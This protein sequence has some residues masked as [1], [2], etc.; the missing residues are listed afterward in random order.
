MAT[1]D[2]K[3]SSKMTKAERRAHSLAVLAD[4]GKFESFVPMHNPK[5]LET[6]NP[7]IGPSVADTINR[8]KSVLAFMQEGLHSEGHLTD[9]ADGADIILDM[10]RNALVKQRDYFCKHSRRIPVEKPQAAK[11]PA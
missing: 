1:K 2:T 4:A 9:S 8:V 7:L 5:E 11:E 10:V 6:Q 3:R